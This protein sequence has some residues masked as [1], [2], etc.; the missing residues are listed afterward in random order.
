MGMSK[1]RGFSL[2]EVLLAVAI[3]VIALCGI[4]ALYT[5][6][7]VLT[8][9]SKNVAI[10]TS[11]AQGLMEQARTDS[12]N[13]IITDY[14]GLKFTVNDIP[15]SMGV[16]YVDNTNPE[17]LKVTISVC[18]KQGT[19]VIGEDQNLNGNL[20]PGEDQ[21]PYNNIIDS[22]VELVTMIANR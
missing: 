12:F 5:S 2:I 1:K 10:A 20:D 17:L 22:P 11:A 19:R 21:P 16:V 8:T 4:L 9:T 6:S 7:I 13:R 18:W 15:N 14:N 3:M